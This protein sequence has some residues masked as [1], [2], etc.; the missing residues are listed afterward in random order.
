MSSPSFFSLQSITEAIEEE[1]EF[2]LEHFRTI[3]QGRIF[4]RA[5]EYF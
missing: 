5:L 1:I 2:L 3:I 4:C